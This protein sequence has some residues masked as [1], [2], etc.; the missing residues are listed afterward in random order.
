MALSIRDRKVQLAVAGGVV[1]I[2][3]VFLLLKAVGGGSENAASPSPS[4]GSVPVPSVSPTVSPTP[5]PVIVFSGR[6][7]FQDLFGASTST[8]PGSSTLPSSGGSSGPPTSGGSSGPPTSGGSSGPP[9]SGGDGGSQSGTNI[10]GHSVLLDDVFVTPGGV[11]KAQVEVDGTVY[12]VAAGESFDGNFK[13]VSFPNA[14]CAHFVYGD[15]G[16]TLC[17]SGGK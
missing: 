15:E 13:L 17:T 10:G 12:T 6:D 16:F 9:A 2:L 3:A 1:A 8:S 14:S 7:P 5:P 11:R 4:V